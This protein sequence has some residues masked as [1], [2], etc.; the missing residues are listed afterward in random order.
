MSDSKPPRCNVKGCRRQSQEYFSN[1]CLVHS[2]LANARWMSERELEELKDGLSTL[3]LLTAAERK[4]IQR[5]SRL[6]LLSDDFAR[7]D[8]EVERARRDGF[9]DAEIDGARAQ[10]E[11]EASS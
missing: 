9:S 4:A 7:L 1:K 11:R 2:T 5:R 8:R 3:T 6:R 10:A